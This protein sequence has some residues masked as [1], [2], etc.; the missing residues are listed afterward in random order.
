M[1]EGQPEN[2]SKRIDDC[3][4]ETFVAEKAVTAYRKLRR[5]R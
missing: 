3:L 4:Q 1:I 5:S 2:L